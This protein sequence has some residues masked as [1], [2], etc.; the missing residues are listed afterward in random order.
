MTALP[1]RC[2]DVAVG[3]L[4]SCCFTSS[5]CIHP[6]AAW[7]TGV[8]LPIPVSHGDKKL[9]YS[10]MQRPVSL[11]VSDERAKHRPMLIYVGCCC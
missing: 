5:M 8:P 6:Q 4:K 3:C 1:E 10:A 2:D 7:K 9:Q 11:E